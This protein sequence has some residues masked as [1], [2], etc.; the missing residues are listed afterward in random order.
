LDL[1]SAK[2][3]LGVRFEG[4]SRRWWLVNHFPNKESRM[5]RNITFAWLFLWVAAGPLIPGGWE[6]TGAAY[7]QEDPFG[8]PGATPRVVD[9]QAILAKRLSFQSSPGQSNVKALFQYIGEFVPDVNFV[10]TPEAARLSLPELDFKNLSLQTIFRLLPQITNQRISVDYESIVQNSEDEN[11]VVLVGKQDHEEPLETRVLSIKQL[12]S[13]MDKATLMEAIDDG[14]KF[15]G[16]DTQPEIGFHE[17]TGLLFVRGT[18]QQTHF[19][20][21]MVSAMQGH[22][23]YG[24]IGGGGGMGGGTGPFPGMGMGGMGGGMPGGFGGPG[25]GMMGEVWV[26]I[27]VWVTTRVAVADTA[28]VAACRR[29]PGERMQVE[30]QQSVVLR[31][32]V[33]RAVSA[34]HKVE[35]FDSE[36]LDPATTV[37]ITTWRSMH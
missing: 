17:K 15:I 1:L 8:G 25:G 29:V 28:E 32:A 24:G 4:N 20:M 10:V 7:A 23:G 34:R 2:K 13:G 19:L 5:S 21:E 26:V 31:L 35:C 37:K 9:P 33:D 36:M 18:P 12:L 3:G 16:S 30:E 22:S 27:Q 11:M 6:L 14:L